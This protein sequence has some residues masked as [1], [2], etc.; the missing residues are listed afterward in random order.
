M[1][2]YFKIPFYENK[3]LNQYR[4]GATSLDR[5]AFVKT[6]K[7]SY[8]KQSIKKTIGI[9]PKRYKIKSNIIFQCKSSIHNNNSNE[10]NN[11]D[12]LRK[13]LKRRINEMKNKKTSDHLDLLWKVTKVHFYLT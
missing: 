10:D 1:Y 11:D 3:S 2:R 7:L 4:K 8:K 5:S 13:D 12:E 6:H 9:V